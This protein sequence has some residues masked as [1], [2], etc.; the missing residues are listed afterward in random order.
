MNEFQTRREVKRSRVQ[1]KCALCAEV[2]PQGSPYSRVSGKFD[3][4]FFDNCFHASCEQL[5]ANYC[6][7]GGDDWYTNDFIYDWLSDY[8]RECEIKD[9]GR[10]VVRCERVL[11]GEGCDE[12]TEEA[13]E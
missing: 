9:C 12:L 8:C 11:R 13:V 1:H 2:I 6:L 4:E 7:A 5:I 10:N 3:G